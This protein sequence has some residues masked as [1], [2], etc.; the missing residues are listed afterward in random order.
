MG[1]AVGIDLGTTNSVVAYVGPNGPE[2]LANPEGQKLTPSVVAVTAD[3]KRLVGL[4]AKR[5]AITNAV[6]TVY[7]AKRLIGRD[8]DSQLIQDLAKKLS[9]N[10]VQGPKNDVRV[11]IQSYTY[12]IP[13][14]SSIVLQE[15]R[16]IAEK[17]L[18]QEVTDAVITVPAYFN[19]NQRQAT[20][21]AGKIA[22]LNVLRILNEPTAAALAYGY[23]RDLNSTVAVYDL[24]GGTFDI[25]ILKINGATFKVLGVNGDSFLGGVDFD[26]RV[27]DWL[28]GEIKKVHPEVDTDGDPMMME[29]LR[30]AAESAKIALSSAKEALVNLPFLTKDKKTGQPIN[31]ET[32]LK[33]ETLESLTGDLIDRTYDIIQKA[34]SRGGVR[35][36]D[37]DDVLLVGGQ[38]RMPLVHRKIKDW[39]GKEPNKRVHP[40]EAVALGA[41]ACAETLTEQNI[42]GTTLVDVTPHDLGIAVAGGYVRVLIPA[43]TA[44]PVEK[45][46]N[47][48]TVRDDQTQVKIIVL[49]GEAER[50]ENNELLG[51]FSLDGLPPK[52][53]G[54]I[55]INVTFSISRDGIVSVSAQDADSGI[56]QKITVNTKN[57]LSAD[58]IREMVEE[59]RDYLLEM[60][61]NETFTMK[62][63]DLETM[64][65]E[66]QV[67]LPKVENQ[68]KS[69]DFGQEILTKT[70]ELLIQ[71]QNAISRKDL[72]ALYNLE[73]SVR[74][75]LAMFQGLSS[76]QSL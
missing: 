1:I 49:Q 2:A 56:R 48:T 9:Y 12:S 19:D 46:E 38:T 18:G 47:F 36:D 15:M 41:A 64:L 26:D 37:V 44:V 57:A 29:R 4:K 21:D 55:H 8:W 70:D 34:L 72:Q 35:M 63:H 7:A 58:E 45:T 16:L 40:D 75:M 52:P 69:S 67:L 22:G 32:T 54:S 3:G 23:G 11:R 33:R 17:A 5:Q 60:R 76:G 31:F 66:I 73:G 51:E 71:S 59:N 24:G 6:N 43:N 68:L 20:V 53:R 74:R 30:E 65:N 39:F 62:R 10:I 13:Q 28:K 27:V 42:S 14:I 61:T 25:S 50:V